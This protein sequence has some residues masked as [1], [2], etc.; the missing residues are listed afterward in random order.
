MKIRITSR[1]RGQIFV[2]ATILIAVFSI[3]IIT[4]LSEIQLNQEEQVKSDKIPQLMSDFIFETEYFQNILLGKVTQDD[5]GSGDIDNAKDN[6]IQELDSYFIRYIQYLNKLGVYCT[7]NHI[8]TNFSPQVNNTF[9]G[10]NYTTI[11]ASINSQIIIKMHS[12]DSKSDFESIL[13][14]YQGYKANY[15]GTHW[16]VCK[17]DINGNI[18]QNINTALVEGVTAGMATNFY[19]GYYQIASDVSTS[20]ILPSRI[21]LFS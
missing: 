15:N 3:S 18:T 5:Y 7:I 19:N 1:R 8:Q 21:I 12:I 10:Q 14:I 4:L 9:S 6:A 2:F 17:I 20:I 13:N 11:E 16:Y